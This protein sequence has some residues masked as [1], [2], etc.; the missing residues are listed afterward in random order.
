MFQ[1]RGRD[2]L[3]RQH[4]RH[5]GAPVGVGRERDHPGRGAA[6]R[7]ALL[8]PRVQVGER[9]HLREVGDADDLPIAGHLGEDPSDRLRDR[10]ADAGVDLVE[11]VGADRVGSGE[12]ALHGQEDPRELTPGRHPPERAGR[13]PGVGGDE[14]LGRL[15]PRRAEPV[16]AR[17]DGAARRRERDLDPAAG[18]GESRELLGDRPA[19]GLRRPAP[20]PPQFGR[21]PGGLAGESGDR[22]GHLPSASLRAGQPGQLRL[23]GLAAR[24]RRL[25]AASVLADDPAQGRDAVVDLGEAIRVAAQRTG[26]AGE[27]APRL[28]HLGGGRAQQGQ[29]LP[30]AGVERG[31]LLEC[32]QGLP[33]ALGRAPFVAVGDGLGIPRRLGEAGGAGEHLALLVEPRVLARAGVDLVEL[34]ELKG[35]VV[36]PASPLPLVVGERPLLAHQRRQ[37]LENLPVPRAQAAGSRRSGEG[38]QQVEVGAGV[39]QGDVLVLAG[40]VDH[41]PHR[42]FQDGHGAER[43]VDED[44]APPRPGHH[45]SHQQLG[46]PVARTVPRRDPCRLEARER[47]VVRREL[48]ERLDRGLVGAF[49][50]EV[51]AH[52]PPEHQVEGADEQRLARPGLAGEHVQAR[53]ETDLHLVHHRETRDAQGRQHGVEFATAP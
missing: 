7:H 42:A 51:D 46:H 37:R 19:E 12:G 23:H 18:H 32:P 34:L 24:E 44:P 11:D 43:A 27:G 21:E 39:E 35:Q 25:Q 8:D 2:R 53:A 36:G 17:L 28:L 47:R 41:A 50:E 22:R 45:P 6:G 3:S 13:L 15:R 5:L 4:A 48:E 52:A 1:G 40:H 20:L 29:D 30:E 38:V 49:P 26:V 9:R 33:D 10:P 31:G 14:D 16:A